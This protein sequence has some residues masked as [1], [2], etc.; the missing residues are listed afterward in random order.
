MEQVMILQFQV[1]VIF[2]LVLLILPLSG[3][4]KMNPTSSWPRV[5]SVGTFSTAQLA[6]SLES[7][8]FYLWVGGTSSPITSFS[9]GTITNTWVHF[10]I[11]RSSGTIKVYQDGVVK[12]TVS[13]AS[14][15]TTSQ[16]FRI[17]SE[18]TSSTYF[19][20]LITNFRWSTIARY[21]ANFTTPTSS[22]P[23]MPTQNYYSRQQVAPLF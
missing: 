8:T 17:G 4:K 7:G 6:V 2:L 5:F 16:T 12:A 11:V 18:G 23:L 20:G 9:H 3:F 19:G 10:A 13:Y 14:S 15:I 22:F 1:Q 21:T